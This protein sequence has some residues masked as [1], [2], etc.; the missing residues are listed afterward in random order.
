MSPG[1]TGCCRHNDCKSSGCCEHGAEPCVDTPKKYRKEQ[2]KMPKTPMPTPEAMAELKA[3]IRRQKSQPGYRFATPVPPLAT[4]SFVIPD[5][6]GSSDTKFLDRF[7]TLGPTEML[8]PTLAYI[9][10]QACELL[11]LLDRELGDR[12]D[13]L[14]RSLSRAEGQL[15]GTFGKSAM[16][17]GDGKHEKAADGLVDRLGDLVRLAQDRVLRDG[18]RLGELQFRLDGLLEKL[19]VTTEGEEK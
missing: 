19:G 2:W 10:E 1:A 12:A 6:L 18:R 8:R 4:D 3:E 7:T 5:L 15:F 9:E 17:D 13:L 14:E 16:P 11:K